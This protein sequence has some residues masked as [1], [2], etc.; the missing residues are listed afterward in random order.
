MEIEQVAEESPEKILKVVVDPAIGLQPFHARKLAF[1]LGLEGAQ[2]KSAVKF[3]S[4][5][6]R[7]FTELDA[8]M[9]EINPLVVTG[10]G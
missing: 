3:L 9:V 1:G 4:A 2:V 8:S 6:F 7:A 5:M 10:S